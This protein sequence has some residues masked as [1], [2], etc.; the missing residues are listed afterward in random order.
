MVIVPVQV[1]LSDLID[2]PTTGATCG[3]SRCQVGFKCVLVNSI[4]TCVGESP[5]SCGNQVC[6]PVREICANFNGKHICIPRTIITSGHITSGPITLGPITSGPITGSGT[7]GG[8][9]VTQYGNQKCLFGYQCL[10]QW[11][12]NL[13]ATISSNRSSLWR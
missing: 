2:P 4:P 1:K 13:C 12:S 3:I 6:D 7:L 9:S 5:A 10:S 11:S 8:I